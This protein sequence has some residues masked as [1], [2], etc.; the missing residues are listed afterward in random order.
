MSYERI[1]SLV[2]ARRREQAG[3][4]LDLGQLIAAGSGGDADAWS[5][6][7]KQVIEQMRSGLDD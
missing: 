7:Q 4:V 1:Q 3:L 6:K 2:A 5:E